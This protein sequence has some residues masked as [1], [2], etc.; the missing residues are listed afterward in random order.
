M[1]AHR[2]RKGSTAADGGLQTHANQAANNRLST[3]AARV[4]ARYAKAPSYSDLFAAEVSS[5]PKESAPEQFM[6]LDLETQAVAAAEVTAPVEQAQLSMVDALPVAK[7]DW[8][9]DWD[10]SEDRVAP[11]HHPLSEALE[12]ES[13]RG[14]LVVD[15]PQGAM[16]MGHAQASAPASAHATASPRIDEEV[17]QAWREPVDFY[18]EAQAVSTVD[19]QPIHGNL[20]EFP[21]ELVAARK[22]RPRRAEG[23]YASFQEAEPQLSIFEVDPT[24]ISS[25]PDVVEQRVEAHGQSGPEWADLKLEATQQQALVAEPVAEVT[26]SKAI[27]LQAAPMSLRVLAAVVDFGLVSISTLAVAA[28]VAVNATVLPT[29]REAEVGGGL[30]F[31]A[32]AVVYLAISY[33][34]ARATPGMKYAMLS[35]RTF[36]GKRP[37]R[38][39]RCRRLGA[40]ALSMLPVGLGAVWALF[41]DEHLA[42]HDRWSGT[43]LRRV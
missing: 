5:A 39:Q 1:A 21:Y 20:I 11:A 10:F 17:H 8:E 40:L 14:G 23:I 28:V 34:L 19:P 27:Q 35:L 29:I 36:D 7:A 15:E 9:P 31:A 37:T 43:Y 18:T 2:K 41:D 26:R 30:L 32:I 12:R 33:T 25:R 13:H 24:T 22:V 38:E 16:E 3:A 42:W 4:A 6:L